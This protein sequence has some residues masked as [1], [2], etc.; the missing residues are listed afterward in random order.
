M[1]LTWLPVA[2]FAL[3]VGGCLGP[4]GHRCAASA[5]CTG[6]VGGVCEPTGYCSFWVDGCQRYGAGAGPLA[7]Q[8]VAA[9]AAVAD[10]PDATPPPDGPAPDGPA[11]DA[12]GDGDG[13]GVLDDRDNCPSVPNPDQ[14][15]EDG[16]RQGDVCDGC[17]HVGG[18]MPSDADGDGVGDACDPDGAVA[19]TVVRFETWAGMPV[20]VPGWTSQAGRWTVAGDV[21]AVDQ[22]TMPVPWM[23]RPL[24]SA[25]TTA[26]SVEVRATALAVASNAFIGVLVPADLTNGGADGCAVVRT[27]VSGTPVTTVG[28]LGLGADGPVA[29]ASTQ[30]VSPGLAA[31]SDLIITGRRFRG[32]DGAWMMRCTVRPFASTAAVTFDYAATSALA[33]TAMGVV[34]SGVSARFTYLWSVAP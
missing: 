1:R 17:P 25:L 26:W 24:T 28:R 34:A 7:D 23:T 22:Q 13:D 12:T 8:C 18:N 33:S 9:D 16:D 20:G 14:H 4:D 10:A 2:M 3:V 31:G 5:E 15:N 19:H 30:V 32:A 29:M 11:P 6:G 27:S 21:V